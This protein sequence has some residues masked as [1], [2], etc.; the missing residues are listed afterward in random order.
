[1]PSRERPREHGQILV[2]FVLSLVVMLL[3]A[4]LVVDGGYAYTQSRTTQNAADFAAMAGTRIIGEKLTGNAANGTP[5][6]VTTAIQSALAANNATLATATYVDGSGASLGNVVGAA[7]IPSSAVGVV[8]T[9]QSTWHPYFLGLVGMNNW[10]AVSTA[11]A[12]TPGTSTG[13]GVL[14]IGLQSDTYDGLTKCAVDQL[15]SCVQ[16]NLTSGALNIPGGFAWLK[17]GATGKCAGYGL[18]MSTTDGCDT[19]QTFLQSE[20]GPPPNSY[21]CCT[22]VGLPGSNDFIGSATGNKPADLSFYI[23]N[24][25]PVWVPIWDTAGGT[26]ANGYYHIVGFGAIIFTGEDTQHGKWLTGAAVSGVGCPG[27]S[28]VPGTT[29]CSAPGGAFTIGVTGAVHLVH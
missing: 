14:P 24:E 7:S 9:A 10:T 26:G 29:Y 19:S 16:Q 5:G 22:A 13:G 28:T 15:D 1:M 27:G 23:Q 8:V 2:L 25:I 20:V 3:I 6:N 12:V 17:F 18:G 11:T 21:G 4:G